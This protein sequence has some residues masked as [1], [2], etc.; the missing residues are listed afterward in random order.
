MKLHVLQHVSFEGPGYLAT[1]A[2]AHHYPL[3]VTRL[4]LAE[5]LPD[6]NGFDSLIVLGG[7]MNVDEEDRFPWLVDE[8]RLI[9]AAIE[10]HKKV[11]GICLGSQLIAQ[12]LGAKVYTGA[13]KEIGWFPI[14]L[15]PAA[16]HIPVVESLPQSLTVFHWHGDTFDLPPGAIHLAASAACA[17]QAFLYPDHVLG[18]QFH[19]EVTPVSVQALVEHCRQELIQAPYIQS[20]AE[21][22][23]QEDHCAEINEVMTSLLDRFFHREGGTHGG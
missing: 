12:V 20:A 14:H 16:Q 8:K 3:T 23:G 6:P 17:H 18:L 19:L 5:P 22:L 7:P 10:G 4:D 2:Q 9:A 1:W 15:T 21:I 11:L 13:H